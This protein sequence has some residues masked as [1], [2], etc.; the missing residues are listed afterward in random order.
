[1]KC[2]EYVAVYVDDL[3]IA[4]ESSMQLYIFKTKYLLKVKGDGKLT[5]HFSADY[6]ED[7]DSTFVS[8]PKK[9]IDKLEKHLKDFS[10]KIHLKDM[11]LHSTGMITQN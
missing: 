9:Y 11:K 8:Q 5:C 1:M 2:Y 7:P 4:A 3:L 10:M 6:F